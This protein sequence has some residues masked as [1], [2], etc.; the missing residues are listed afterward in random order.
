MKKILIVD[1]SP[2]SRAIIKKCLPKGHA[3]EVVEA[4][5]GKEGL[6]K[7]KEL[8]PAVTFLDLTMPVMDGFEALEAIK[9]VNSSAVVLVLTADIQQKAVEKVMALGAHMVITKP[10]S[11]ESIA[12]ALANAELI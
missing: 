1:D 3:F 8:R 10:P 4:G 7:F 2:V 6:E 5:D 12:A 9:K 11:A